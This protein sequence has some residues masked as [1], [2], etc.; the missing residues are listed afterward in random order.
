MNTLHLLNKAINF[1]SR[2]HRDQ[3]RKG[4]DI[5][6]I[7]HPLAVALI[8]SRMT[9]DENIIIAGILHDT[10]EDC[11]PYGSIT[12]G[13]IEKEFNTEIARMV[14]DLT[15]PPFAKGSGGARQDKKKTWILRK[16]MALEHVKEMSHDSLLVKSADVLHN[17]SSLNDDLQKE[18]ENVFSRFNA[19]KANTIERYQ[20]LIPEIRKAWPAAVVR[21]AQDSGEVNS[22]NPLMKD[23]EYE[24][25]RLLKLSS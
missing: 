4:T 14:D 1:A 5:P 2:V 24:L 13:M 12:K 8:L 7:T 9:K 10:I 16:K 18:G 23:L 19:P 20:G 25:D 6:Y 17:L 15:E 11:E 22:G 3:K 21:H